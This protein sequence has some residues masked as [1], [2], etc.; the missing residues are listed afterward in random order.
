ML[1]QKPRPEPGTTGIRAADKERH[2]LFLAMVLLLVALIIS[3]REGLP[4][5]V[6]RRSLTRLLHDQ[7]TGQRDLTARFELTGLFV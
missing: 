2:K 1:E 3:S 6:W 4:G 5:L 7:S